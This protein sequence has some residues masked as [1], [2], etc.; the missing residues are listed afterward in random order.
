MLRRSVMSGSLQSAIK[1]TVVMKITILIRICKSHFFLIRSKKFAIIFLS[2]KGLHL[3]HQ[4]HN[5][6]SSNKRIHFSR[7]PN[8]EAVISSAVLQRFRKRKRIAYYFFYCCFSVHH[9]TIWMRN[10]SLMQSNKYIFHLSSV[11]KCFGQHIAHHQEIN[12][13]YKSAYGVRP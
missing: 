2:R 4:N 11:S 13:M 8:L 9:T 6:T 10:T 5:V 7:W 3:E 12:K 1:T